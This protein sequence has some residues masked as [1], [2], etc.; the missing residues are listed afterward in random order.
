MVNGFCQ[1]TI[2]VNGFSMAFLHVNHWCQWFFQWFFTCESLVSM[3]FQW[4][5]SDLNHWCQWFFQWFFTIEPLPLH[6]WFLAHH[7]HRCFINGF[8][9]SERWFTKKAKTQKNMICSTK[10]RG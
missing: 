2:V 3:V 9:E 5:F 4:F 10:S 7:L 8:A 1:S 6:E